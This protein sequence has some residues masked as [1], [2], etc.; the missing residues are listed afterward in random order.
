MGNS[1]AH[2]IVFHY[3][4]G[5]ENCSRKT[6]GALNAE[7]FERIL[8]Y[9]S[10]RHNLLPAHEFYQKYKNGSIGNNDVCIT[11]DDGLSCAFE[12]A[13]PILRNRGL[14]AFWFVYTLPF[15]GKYELLEVYRI[16]RNECFNSIED[17]YSQ[18]YKKILQTKRIDWISAWNSDEAL[19]YKNR[20]FYTENDRRF[21]FMRDRVL[22]ENQY[23]I[24]MSELLKDSDFDVDERC[25]GLWLNKEKITVLSEEGNLVGLH[26]HSHPTT[27]NTLSKKKKLE[28]Y[29]TNQTILGDIIGTK[30][31]VASYPCS[32]YD[33]EAIEVLKS[34]GVDLAFTARMENKED[35]MKIPRIDCATILKEI[36]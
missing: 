21:R 29:L 17:F 36:N 26:S 35:V 8:D 19:S 18:F 15:T 7:E 10:S 14:T 13:Q 34:I 4:F 25:A 27:M 30:P 32:E 16:F 24:I 1:F 2:G 3:F 20:G 22:G 31:Y 11:F 23:E 28:E 33:D 5:G 9:Y 6:Q 12:V